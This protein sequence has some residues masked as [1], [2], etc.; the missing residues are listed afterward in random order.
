[1]SDMSL[2]Y[3]STTGKLQT[4]AA[5]TLFNATRAELEDCCC[6]DTSPAP[7][8]CPAGLASEYSV[9]VGDA[10][11]TVSATGT[12]CEWDWDGGEALSG[13]SLTYVLLT[14][15]TDSAPSCFWGTLLMGDPL[16]PPSN[17]QGFATKATGQTPIGDYGTDGTCGYAVS[18]A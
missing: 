13:G 3:N 15:D 10:T 2:W 16:C 17:T 5:D 6:E 9:T 12:D 11:V 1:M 7:C 4:N 18:V 14:L 8:T